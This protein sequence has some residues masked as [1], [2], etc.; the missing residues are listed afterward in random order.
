VVEGLFHTIIVCQVA[1][2]EAAVALRMHI[3]WQ[4]AHGA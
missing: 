1:E 3:V 2:S 4:Q